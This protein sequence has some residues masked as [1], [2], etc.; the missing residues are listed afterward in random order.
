MKAKTIGKFLLYTLSG[1]AFLALLLAV[2]IW[3][4]Y[5][6]KADAHTRVMARIDVRQPI[7]Q[8]EADAINTWL[9]QQKGVDHAL[10]NP[11]TQIVVFTFSPLQTSGNTI[12]ANFKTHFHLNAG[13]FTPTEKDLV[14]SC[15]VAGSSVYYKVY[16]FIDHIL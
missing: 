16:K 7:S 11:Q 8:D 10:V 3:W 14:S 4:V 12:T 13:R 15:P 2:H 5:R 6:P 9:Y 1:I